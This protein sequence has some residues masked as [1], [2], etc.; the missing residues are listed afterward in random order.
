MNTL[1]RTREP[2]VS[3]SFD[4]ITFHL[5]LVAPSLHI[6]DAIKQGRGDQPAQCLGSPLS[7]LYVHAPDISDHQPGR[8]G[9]R[10]FGLTLNVYP[11]SWGSVL[12]E[13]FTG[14]EL[15]SPDPE[16]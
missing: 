2:R 4:W 12:K 13:L 5:E 16:K 1:A 3:C 14:E 7:C 11:Y 6:S 10:A 8:R 9:A 15:Y